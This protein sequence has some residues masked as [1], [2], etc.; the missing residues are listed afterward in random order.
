[1]K[2]IFLNSYLSNFIDP[3][4]QDVYRL[5]VLSFENTA[6]KTAHTGYHLPKVDYSVMNDSKKFFWSTLKK[7][8]SWK[9]HKKILEKSLSILLSKDTQLVAYLINLD[10]NDK[11]ISKDQSK[12]Q[13][14]DVD[15]EAIQKT[16]F[17]ANL[18]REGVI[19]SNKE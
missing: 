9:N 8:S 1:M 19:R 7:K 6:D 15:P 16:Y 2:Q 18:E 5:F 11:T 12:K 13:A 3:S 4:F 10:K 14:L 17:P